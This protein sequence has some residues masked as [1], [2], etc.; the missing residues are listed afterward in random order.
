MFDGT[1]LEF[2]ST[3]K[4]LGVTFD[5]TLSWAPQISHLSR[6]SKRRKQNESS[7]E[8]DSAGEKI[9]S[10][11]QSSFTPVAHTEPSSSCTDT[12]EAESIC[13][14]DLGL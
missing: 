5:N 3:V 10:I 6:T 11:A 14:N 9:E 4:N 2:S 13:D 8:S 1:K 12:A 7:S